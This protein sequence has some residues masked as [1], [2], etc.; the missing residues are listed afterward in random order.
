MDLS[1][2]STIVFLSV[3]TGFAAIALNLPVALIA[4]Y[5]LERKLKRES[6]FI[7]GIINLP[8]VMPPV[9]TGYLLL[10]VLGKKGIIGS[11]FYSVTGRSLAYSWTAALLASM[12]VSFPLIIRSIRTA[13]AMV[14]RR[15]ELAAMTLGAGGFS[16]FMRITLPLI[17]PGVINGL[18][19]GFARSLGEFGATITFAGNIEGETRTIPLAVYSFLQI[20]GKEKEASLL[21]LI[22]IAISFGSLFL[23]SH[24]SGRINHE[25]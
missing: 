10:I 23:S 5:Y 11:F 18:L 4:A 2:I 24:L 12:I 25:S 3:K 15:L 22:S 1:R 13:M 7:E 9:T 19:L 6:P 20:P 14:D 17:L 16:L 21:V 8:L